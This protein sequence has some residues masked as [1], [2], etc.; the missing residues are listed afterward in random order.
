[1]LNS[2]DAPSYRNVYVYWGFHF[3]TL[4]QP[5]ESEEHA[6][7]GALMFLWRL[8]L[9]KVVTT[10]DEVVK[11]N[12][13]PILRFVAQQVLSEIRQRGIRLPDGF[14]EGAVLDI[15]RSLPP[16]QERAPILESFEVGMEDL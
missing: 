9:N 13:V 14:D 10:K 8:W 16:V 7:L 11:R 2:I 5:S 3:S 4:K 12:A 1:M 15:E 6:I